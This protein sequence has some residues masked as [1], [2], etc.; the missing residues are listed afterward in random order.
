MERL[1]REYVWFCRT[2]YDNYFCVAVHLQE[3]GLV[4]VRPAAVVLAAV[5]A[6]ALAAPGL[7]AVARADH[8]IPELTV[9]GTGGSPGIC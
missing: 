6:A 4:P 5:L 9:T 1:T 8:L 7:L 2:K 3:A